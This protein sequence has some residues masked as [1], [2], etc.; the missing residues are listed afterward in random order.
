MGIV[1]RQSIY[2]TLISYLGVAIGYINLLYL[3]PKFLSLEQVGLF[4]TIQDA[5]ILFTPF[6][7]FGLTQS[8]FRFYPQLVKD[9]KSSH[10]FIT[11]M[12]LMALAG[13]AVFFLVFK[14]FE[15]P[16]LSYFQDNAREI[17]QY[18]SLVLWLTLVLVMIAVLEAFSRSLL[19]TVVPNLLREVMAR[20]F[21]S[22]L[23]LLYFNG[24]IS[25][26]QFIIGS[27]I[28]YLIWLLILL[29]YLWSQG[30]ISLKTNLTSLDQTKFPELFK[31]SLL[32]FAGMAG[33]ILIGKIDSMMVS[34]LLGLSANA[35]YTT[36]FYMA[37]I[38]E[39]PKRALGQIIMPLISNAFER[40]EIKEVANLY[41]K[42]S[43]NQFIIG[44]LLLIGIWINLD[45]IFDLMPKG[46]TYVLGKW[47]VII[48]GFGKLID[49]LFGPSSEIIILSKYYRFNIILI[50]ALATL[51]IISNNILIPRYGIEG[52]AW[53]SA[54]ALTTFNIIKFIF[55]YY[56]F[57]IQPFELTT[58][59]VLGIALI[60]LLINSILPKVEN[61][62]IDIGFRSGVISII[63]GSSIIV[64]KVSPETNTLL[65]KGINLFRK[66]A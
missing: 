14:I 37:T 58:A 9:Q 34:A 29:F 39:I 24:N 31:Y 55:I 13:F 53:G 60:A 1:I 63:F 35:I 66:K 32:S 4:R 21:L 18:T 36:A 40:N 19:K 25:F 27:V 64:T 61:T 48:V 22:V 56:K 45:N 46:E 65:Q 30:E 62:L 6:A 47:V 2:S 59:K 17:I 49:M 28:G 7:Q 52:A 41:R 16:L 12:A 15:A 3:Y 10:T 51:A 38:I 8:I 23:V 42:T 20:L 11:L 26:N 54:F 44:I 33:L 57:R 43:I 5:A 50:L